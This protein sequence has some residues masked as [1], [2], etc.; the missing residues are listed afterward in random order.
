MSRRKCL[1]SGLLI[2]LSQSELH[3]LLY[4]VCR[5]DVCNIDITDIL[6]ASFMLCQ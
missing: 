2:I 6:H 1:I 5:K 4:E 3:L